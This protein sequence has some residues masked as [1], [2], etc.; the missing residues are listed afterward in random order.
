MITD[1]LQDA[2]IPVTS[3]VMR[4]RGFDGA[5]EVDVSLG[6]TQIALGSHDGELLI[7]RGMSN[8]GKVMIA[9]GGGLLLNAGVGFNMGANDTLT[10]IFDQLN[11]QWIEIT[12]SDR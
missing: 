11:S 4:I 8:D 2:S 12:R 6:A 5:V 9:D 7:I 3:G 10:L 1:I